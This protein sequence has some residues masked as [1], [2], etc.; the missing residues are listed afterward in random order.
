MNKEF[1]LMPVTVGDCS[2]AFII[3]KRQMRLNFQKQYRLKVE[4]V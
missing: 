2:Q 1:I 4:E 3:P